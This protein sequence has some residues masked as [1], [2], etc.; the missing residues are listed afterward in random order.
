MTKAVLDTNILVSSLLASGP[1]ALIIDLVANGRIIPFYN[2]LILQEYLEV[3]SR[4]KFG[5]NSL[6]VTRLIEDLIRVGVLIECEH[7]STIPISDE[8]DRMFYD[9]AVKAKAFLVTGNSR[10][11]P[12]KPFIVNPVQF[13]DIY[14]RCNIQ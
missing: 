7:S 5:F 12:S 13:L 4:K 14:S 8:D 2:S 3:L 10:H 9:T 1:P 11:F 6:Q